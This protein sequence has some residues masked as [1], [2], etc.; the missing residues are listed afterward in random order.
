MLN[1][2]A[3]AYAPVAAVLFGIFALA[4]AWLG[5]RYGLAR[6]APMYFGAALV[7]FILAIPISRLVARRMRARPGPDDSA[8]EQEPP[9]ETRAP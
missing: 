3:V 7:S 4:F 9:R 8:K 2:A 1:R 5:P 6:G